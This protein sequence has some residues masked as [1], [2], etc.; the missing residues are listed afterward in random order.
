MHLQELVDILARELS[1][2][3]TKKL[4]GRLSQYHRIQ[5]SKEFLTVV[6]LL[7]DELKII[8]DDK[9]QIHEYIADGTKRYY[10]WNSPISW[11]IESG[12]LKMVEPEIK[13]LCRFTEVP[14]S[15]CTHSKS[16][17]VTAEVVHI[18]EGKREDFEKTDVKGKIVLSSASPRTMIE[19]LHENG[20]IG[21]IAYPSE[22]RAKGYLEMIQYVGLWPNADNVD[23]S[24]FGFSLSRKQALEIINH[25]ETGRKVIVKAEIAANLYKGKMHVLSTKIE[26]CKKPEEEIIVIA[27]ICHPAPSANDNASGSALLLEIYRTIKALIDKK[28]VEQP[29]RTIRFLWVPEFSGT[30]PWIEENVKSNS[31][32]PILCLNLDM[33]GEHPS[34]VG[35][36]FTLNK[37][38]ISTPTFLNDLISE[39]ID[40]VKDNNAVIEQG[41]W[42]FPWNFRIKQ[43][44]GGS[45]HL[46]FNDEP[47]RIPSVMFGHPDTFHHTNLDTIEK[48][49]PTTLKRV[50]CTAVATVLAS[51]F[52][53]EYS[54]EVQRICIKGLQKRKGLFLEM[55]T[56]ELNHLKEI[57]SESDKKLNSF[58]LNQIINTFENYEKKVFRNIAKTFSNL[59]TELVE[60]VNNDLENFKQSIQNF[61]ETINE[62]EIDEEVSELLHKVPVRKWDGPLNSK[63][64]YQALNAPESLKESAK[65]TE[66]KISEIKQLAKILMKNYGGLTF[67]I[68]NLIDNERNINEILLNLGLI[69]WKLLP[70]MSLLSFIEMLESLQLIEY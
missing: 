56:S 63:I 20:A 14:E 29:E 16:T 37:A 18:N 15:I 53:A 26:G 67:E 43:F 64:I 31:F 66:E 12:S 70:P 34:L 62:M 17:E 21:I 41:G 2:E 35:Y 39:I 30:L 45:D 3:R 32:T 42:Q 48:V 40:K 22:Q 51:S 8:G 47:T 10:S 50:G 6:E 28:I 19:R 55:L 27:H 54:K 36:P 1:G 25:I 59:D 52:T 68:I 23:K 61:V 44:A 57:E 13:N 46:L 65:F 69:D 24:T 60:F 7:K 9:Y 49:D 5:A 33:V 11:D 4:T 38:S 58:L